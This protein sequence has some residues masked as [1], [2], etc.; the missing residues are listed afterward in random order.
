[1]GFGRPLVV[2][3]I[4][5]FG[6]TLGSCIQVGTFA[7]I[8]NAECQGTNLDG[9]CL[10]AGCAHPD[11]G[12]ESGERY[13][14]YAE[15][16]VAGRCVPMGGSSEST[17]PASGSTTTTS[18]TTA[19]NPTEVS[20]GPPPPN[21]QCNGIDDDG[22]G[23]IDEWSPDNATECE[24]CLMP[25]ICRACHLF[26]DDETNPTHTYWYCRGDAWAELPVFCAA[27]DQ[28]GDPQAHFVS[29]HD[30]PENQLIIQ[31]LPLDPQGWG[32]T[33]IGLRNAGSPE[34]PEWIWDDGT[35]L[36]YHRLGDSFD[37]YQSDH[38][39]VSMNGNGAWGLSDCLAAF[40]FVCEAT[41]R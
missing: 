18:I 35:P 5:S 7:C 3:L 23:L 10:A 39:C 30:D 13:S 14:R 29:I 4:A 36:D 16:D 21:E 9:R 37:G 15:P 11:E 8:D 28:P 22:D 41:V 20:T 25:E 24:I 12:C 26:V 40:S 38:T 33:W 19:S 2:A 6:A 1:M 27:L 34:S 31:Q 32:V 17:L